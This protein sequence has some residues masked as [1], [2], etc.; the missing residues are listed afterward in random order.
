[1]AKGVAQAVNFSLR[2]GSLMIL[3]RLV[4]PGD[5]GLLGMVTAVT[6][7]LSLFRDLGLSTATIQ[8]TEVSDAQ[9]STLFWINLL[10]GG[11]LSFI[12]LG[13]APL[14][15]SFYR[16]PRLLA[17]TM[18]LASVF[19]L[20]AASVQH[21]ATLQ[22]QMRFTALAGIETGSLLVS[23]IV[24]VVLAVGG[25]GYWALV[26]MAIVSPAAYTVLVWMVAGWV[27]RWPQRAAGV[28]S[29]VR[30]GGAVTLNSVIV[31]AAYNLEKILLGRFWGAEALG[32]YGRAYQL[33]SIPTENLNSAIGE[34]ALSALSRIKDDP[35]RLRSYFLKGYSLLVAF[36]LPVTVTCALFADDLVQV[37][38]GA[39]WAQSAAIFRLLTPTILVFAMINPMWWLMVSLGLVNRSL[40]IALVLA[41]LVIV[42]YVI[43]L[44]YGPKGV[45]LGYSSVMILWVVPH[46]AWCVRGT[47]ISLQ[48]IFVAIARPLASSVVAAAIAAAIPGALLAPLPGLARLVV[49]VAVLWVVYA[50][51]LLF[52]MG[53]AAPYLD[54]V[55]A[56]TRRSSPL[57]TQPGAETHV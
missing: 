21:S 48:D 6:G 44:P 25:Y 27:P 2:I 9:V 36:T 47:G 5:F 54:L 38:L 3:A 20:N 12:A 29:M 51:I 37:V 53:Q 30:F 40:R 14:V 56:T 57:P 13:L 11:V 45:A 24:G 31:Y 43:G 49:E 22:R 28:L 32:T 8:R 41:P 16:E 46:L 17:V 52:V 15:A 42:G 34:V 7:A 35:P 26:W 4:S 1:M 39:K 10:V 23:V 19:V 33:V 55:R 50:A 18:T